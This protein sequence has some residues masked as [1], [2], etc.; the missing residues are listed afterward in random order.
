MVNDEKK[1]KGQSQKSKPSWR[2]GLQMLPLSTR[3]YFDF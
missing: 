2:A 3:V 1:V